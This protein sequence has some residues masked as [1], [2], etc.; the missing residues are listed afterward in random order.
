MVRM[1]RAL[2]PLLLAVVSGCTNDRSTPNP[3]APS[4]AVTP[5]AVP[6]QVLT[7]Y[8]FDTAFRPVAGASIEVLDGSQAGKSAASDANGRFSLAGAFSTPTTVRA[9]K[10][11]YVSQTRTS[12]TSGPYGPPWVAFN[13]DLVATPTDIAGNYTITFVADGTC[14]GVPEDLRT[15]S[16][17]ATIVARPG[18]ARAN[19]SYTLTAAGA[20]FLDGYNTIQIGVAGDYASFAIYQGEAEGLVEETAPATFLG[21][22]GFGGS[23]LGTPPASTLSVTFAGGFEYCAVQPGTAWTQECNTATIAHVRCESKNQRLILTRR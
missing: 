23:S 4:A 2:V 11:G 3:V 14:A 10:E 9:S 8:V 15:R 5:V 16:Y 12:Q 21:L 6:Q 18:L 1:S 19:T 7:G 20:H 22:D 17:P 13:L